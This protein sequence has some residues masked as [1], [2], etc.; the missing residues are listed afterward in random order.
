MEKFGL[1]LWNW[2][3]KHETVLWIFILTTSF[4]IFHFEFF[5]LKKTYIN[6]W[7]FKNQL[8]YRDLFPKVYN[9]LNQSSDFVTHHLMNKFFTLDMIR[10]GEWPLWN[11]F[12]FS[13][14][15]IFANGASLPFSPLNIFAKI[16]S[17]YSV[18]RIQIALYFLSGGALMY[19]LLYRIYRLEKFSAFVGAWLYLFCPFVIENIDFDSLLSFLWMFPAIVILLENAFKKL[20]LKFFIWIGI[21]LGCSTYLS[22]VHM[23]L[24]GWLLTGLYAGFKMLQ[25]QKKEYFRASLYTALSFFICFGFSALSLFPFL[26]FL[27]HSQRDFPSGGSFAFPIPTDIFTGLYPLLLKFPRIDEIL[28]LVFKY[29]VRLTGR[30]IYL[31]IFSFLAISISIC[32][33]FKSRKWSVLYFFSTIILIYYLSNLFSL[34]DFIPF[35]SLFMARFWAL[36][37]FAS[38]II[39]SIIIQALLN[40][41]PLVVLFAKRITKIITY[42]VIFPITLLSFI[43]LLCFEHIKIYAQSFIHDVSKV[44]LFFE[45]LHDFM[46]TQIFLSLYALVICGFLYFLFENLKR[47]PMGIAWK[48]C[49]VWLLLV[50]DICVYGYRLRPI[51]VSEKELFQ[52]NRLLHFIQEDKDL[53]RIASLQS[54][55]VMVMKPNLGYKYGLYDIGGQESLLDRYYLRFARKKLQNR[56]DVPDDAGGILDFK[57]LNLKLA[58]LMN[59]KYIIALE[60]K[61]VEGLGE[62]ERVFEADGL[63]V[64]RNPFYLPRAYVVDTLD[65][66]TEASAASRWTASIMVYRPQYIEISVSADASKYVVLADTFYPG[67]QAFVDGKSVEIVRA[68]GI[69]RAVHIDGGMHKVQFFYKPKSLSYGMGVVGL[70]LFLLMLSLLIKRGT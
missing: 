70:T 25:L 24:Q 17:S 68:N 48:V 26:E 29:P 63:H 52:K 44:N 12:V 41:D 69:Y 54:D 30:G 53:F 34:D 5:F 49:F 37:I 56:A 16:V 39:S 18:Y 51:A 45:R 42:F 46:N 61:T 23:V 66:E 9:F 31:G 64:Y 60:S 36:F 50:G 19:Y 55:G 11:P 38:A 10:Q 40:R 21:F 35:Y 7:I 15:P 67:W 28:S 43:V 6:L 57:G 2:I 22:H 27:F 33:W 47:K 59:V 62:K 1:V 65:Y 3:K 58:G 14:F 20:E 8:P 32:L 4:F 13:G